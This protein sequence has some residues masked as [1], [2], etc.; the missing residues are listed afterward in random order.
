L[1]LIDEILPG[2]RISF[3]ANT[4]IYYVEE[5]RDFLA[6]VD[7]LF[8]SI[9]AG[10]LTAYLSVITL[11]EGLVAPLR[12]GAVVLADRYRTILSRTHGFNT[13]SLDEATAERAALIRSQ[14]ALRTPDAV[15]AAAAIRAGCAHLVANDSRFRRVNELNTLVISD[16][17]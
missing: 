3:D 7:P 5:H 9:L 8:E 1:G 2:S 11:T 17:V 16:F 4:L 12:E 15:V 14:Y 6:V 13:Q 10:T